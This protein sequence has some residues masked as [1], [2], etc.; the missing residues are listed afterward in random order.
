M[1]S[2]PMNKDHYIHR[3][4]DECIVD[5]DECQNFIPTPIPS[6][7][8][9]S[10]SHPKPPPPP[11]HRRC[12]YTATARRAD[13]LPPP[14]TESAPLG[15]APRGATTG[16]SCTGRLDL[17]APLVGSTRRPTLRVDLIGLYLHRPTSRR[18]HRP[19][20]AGLHR[21]TSPAVV[22]HRR[23]PK[24]FFQVYFEFI[25]NVTKFG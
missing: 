5:P 2:Q 23:P 25:L 20:L 1:Y 17:V 4:T 9:H 15:V 13:S 16:P 24:V 10:A 18:L 21:A 19:P 14:T 22:H 12:P 8:P 6:P 11:F 7:P 3:L